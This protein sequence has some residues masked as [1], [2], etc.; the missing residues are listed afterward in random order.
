MPNDTMEKEVGF[1][2][3]TKQYLLT[4]EGLPSVHVHDIIVDEEGRRALV[5]ALAHDSVEAITLDAIDIRPGQRF[6]VTSRGHQFSVGDHLL[7]RVISALGD[8]I[9]GKS[10]FPLKNAPL[11]FEIEAPGL[12]DRNP[13]QDQLVTGFSMI[14]TVLPIG[15]GQRQ[16][17]MGPVRSGIDV[18]V[19]E[20]IKNQSGTNHVAIYVTIGKPM[21]QVRQIAEELFAS[22][23]A[24]YTIILAASADDPTPLITIAPAVGFYIAEHF[25]DRG[26]NVLLVLDDLY[27][28][29]KYLREIA[30]LQ[31]RLP[32]R[33]SYPGDIFYQQAQLIERA[34][35]FKDKGSITLLPVLQ[36]D[37]EGYTDLITTNIMGTTDGHLSFSSSLFSQ[38]TFPPVSD[39]ESVTRVGKHTQSVVQKQ[40][41]S[42]IVSLL[43]ESKVQE[44]FTQFGTQLSEAGREVIRM[45]AIIRALLSQEQSEHISPEAQAV[46]LGTV[47]TTFSSG[48]D[49]AFFKTHRANLVNAVTLHIDLEEVRA[50][51]RTATSLDAFLKIVESKGQFFEQICRK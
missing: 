29:A 48:K 36:T 23:A 21:T 12:A 32:G 13:V 7:G 16:L 40:L 35:C 8:P 42:S 50:S 19:R 43:A 49:I 3:S 2:K 45:G 51:V 4:L 9:D 22:S 25:R 1:V 5:T 10:G 41:S 30:L 38:G 27:T 20:V 26:S 28:H 6:S 24:K 11:L 31:G 18:F 44:R 17:L 39:E 33:E 34:G 37:M 15:I 46:L 47:F 14:D